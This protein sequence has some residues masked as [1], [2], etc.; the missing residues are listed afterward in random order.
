M[1]YPI[2][3]PCHIILWQ[4]SI[5][6][7]RYLLNLW[8]VLMIC[9]D[10]HVTVDIC[11]WHWQLFEIDYWVSQTTKLKFKTT[12]AT[13]VFYL[14]V[15]YQIFY[16]IFF[17]RLLNSRVPVLNARVQSLTKNKF[18]LAGFTTTTQLLKW[19][20]AWGKVDGSYLCPINTL[21]K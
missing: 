20:D 5:F 10:W 8:L 3:V 17:Y 6:G 14:F 9:G 12:V 19:R 11:G 4:V 18:V 2:S 15:K 1:E 13:A 21:D 16:S 7:S